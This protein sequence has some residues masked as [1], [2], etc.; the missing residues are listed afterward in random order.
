[1]AGLRPGATVWLTA[2]TLGAPAVCFTGAAAE[3]KAIDTPY[4]VVMVKGKEHR[5]HED[6]VRRTDPNAPRGVVQVRPKPRLI[7]PDGAEEIPLF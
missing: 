6:N 4:L 7:L 5:I 1:M 3:V 2:K